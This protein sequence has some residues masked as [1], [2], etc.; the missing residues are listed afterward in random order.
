MPI[1]EYM[2]PACNTTFEEWI[3]SATDANSDYYTCPHCTAQAQRMM[4]PSTFI[5][6]GG[7]WYV[8]EYGANA[9]NAKNAKKDTLNSEANP[10]VKTA[11][12]SKTFTE[13]ANNTKVKDTAQVKTTTEA[14]AGKSS[15][16][17]SSTGSPPASV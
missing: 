14:P 5:L 3:K 8:T 10:Q 12:N 2:C 4:S 6:K 16:Q 9:D 15:A 7:G 13:A 1:Y 17:T 11:D